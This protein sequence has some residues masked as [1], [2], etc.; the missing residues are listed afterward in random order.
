MKATSLIPIAIA[1]LFASCT[2]G[3][4]EF[5]AYSVA[6][7]LQNAEAQT[8]LDKLAKD[9][10]EIWRLEFDTAR[11]PTFT[12]ENASYYVNVGDPPITGSIRSSIAGVNH[13]NDALLGLATGERVSALTGQITSSV[14]NFQ[15]AKAGFSST[16]QLTSAS[17]A[18]GAFKNSATS[19]L[20]TL[21]VAIPILEAATTAVS[22]AQFRSL[23]LE[24]YP[25]LRQVLLQ[26]KSTAGAIYKVYLAENISTGASRAQQLADRELIAGWVILLD[27]TI[28]AMD[29]AVAA[30]QN[31]SADAKL[32]QLSEA[33]IELR[34][35]AE[36]LRATR[37]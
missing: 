23:L 6:Y 1:C 18:A 9:E 7:N 15:Q 21:T 11:T 16:A 4:N 25:S 5:Q 32:N 30:V 31:V 13:F 19:A 8:V 33:S 28:V 17:G 2:A 36:T 34:V 10:R 14:N 22:R 29:A 20:P 35:L 12:P 3:V 37:N 24:A 27:Q 26:M